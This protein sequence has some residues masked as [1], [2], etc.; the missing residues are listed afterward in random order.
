MEFVVVSTTVD[1]AK[2]AKAIAGRIVVERLAACVQQVPIR[3]VYRWKGKIESASEYLLLAKTR[4]ALASELVAFIRKM[5]PYEL[6]EIL[7][8]PIKG[9]LAGYLEW[10]V[11]ETR[12]GKSARKGGK[13]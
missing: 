8:M 2:K 6:P 13:R 3:S 12:G 1:N 4:A 7:V 10:I 5:H 9:G 11:R